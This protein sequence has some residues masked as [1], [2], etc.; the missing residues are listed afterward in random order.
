L[1]NGSFI[2][3]KVTTNNDTRQINTSSDTSIATI[4]DDMVTLL[5]EGII[6]ITT[7]NE[8]SN[9]F[10]GGS[11]TRALKIIKQINTVLSGFNISSKVFGAGTF[12]IPPPT[13]TSSAP[14]T[15][16]SENPLVASISNNLLTVTGV[17]KTQITALQSSNGYYTAA[18]MTI[19]FVVTAAT[20]ENAPEI[21][22]DNLV[23]F[24][25]STASYAVINS[26][27]T[28]IPQLSSGDSQKTLYTNSDYTVTISYIKID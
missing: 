27:I 10:F 5:D 9:N 21:T 18:S 1:Y 24:L 12:V 6:T 16:I 17:G 15:Y 22:E 11:I 19:D 14:F 25:S 28:S 2:L 20:K 3:D 13:S 23:E 4:E 26:P 8:D 7:S